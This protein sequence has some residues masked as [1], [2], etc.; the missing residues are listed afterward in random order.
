MSGK[1]TSMKALSA[2]VVYLVLVNEDSLD[3]FTL[4]KLSMTS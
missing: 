1:V 3:S 2:E 4:V